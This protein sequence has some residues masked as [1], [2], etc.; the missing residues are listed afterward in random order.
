M[1]TPRE[2]AIIS[3]ESWTIVCKSCNDRIHFSSSNMMV[4]SRDDE[5]TSLDGQNHWT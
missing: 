5:I 3:L 1:I 2:N 4:T